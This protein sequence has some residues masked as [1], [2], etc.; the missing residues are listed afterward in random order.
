MIELSLL[1]ISVNMVPTVLC[2]I[3]KLPSV[4]IHDKLAAHSAADKW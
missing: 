4:V 3:V 1:S 2:Q